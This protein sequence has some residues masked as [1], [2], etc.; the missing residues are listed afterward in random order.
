RADGFIGSTTNL[1]MVASTAAFLAAGK[2]GLAPTVKR[3]TDAACKLVDRP[4]A[5]G[6]ISNDPSG[7]TAVD[8]LAFGALGHIAGVGIVLGLRATGNL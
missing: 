5:A 2:F 3:G 8:T 6:L 4:N 7:F 1:I